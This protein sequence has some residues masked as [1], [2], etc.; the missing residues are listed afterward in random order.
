MKVIEAKKE[1]TN[2]RGFFVTLA[3]TFVFAFLLLGCRHEAPTTT[4]KLHGKVVSIDRLGHQLIVDH[5]AIPGFMD[6]MTMPYPVKDNS[7]LD[8]VSTGD[9]IEADLRVQE[10]KPE[11]VTLKVLKK[12]GAGP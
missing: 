3:S 4:Y 6:A 9:E 12:A 1:V 2:R 5:D 8:Q 10:D 11:I 7:M